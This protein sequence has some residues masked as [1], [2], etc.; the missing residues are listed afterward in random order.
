MSETLLGA[1]MSCCIEFDQA[2][3]DEVIVY[4]VPQE[5]S[6]GPLMNGIVSEYFLLKTRDGGHSYYAINYCPFCGKPRSASQQGFS[7]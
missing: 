2:V 3:R 1:D 7:G 6:D 5:I 4:S